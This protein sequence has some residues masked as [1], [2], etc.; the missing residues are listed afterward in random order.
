MDGSTGESRG[1]AAVPKAVVLERGPHRGLRPGH[2]H[3]GVVRALGRI[4]CL[5]KKETTRKRR[6]TAR[7]KS[8]GDVELTTATTASSMEEDTKQGWLRGTGERVYD[9]VNWEG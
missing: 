7:K 6:E 8:P 4:N 5:L 1:R 9:E 2:V 3:K